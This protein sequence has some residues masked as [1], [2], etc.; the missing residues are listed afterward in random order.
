MKNGPGQRNKQRSKNQCEEQQI[1][2]HQFYGN[3]EFTA[4][5]IH[6]IGQKFL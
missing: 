1:T 3:F 5:R 2:N 4:S 6:L